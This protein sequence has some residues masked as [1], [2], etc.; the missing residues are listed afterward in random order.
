MVTCIVELLRLLL[1]SAAS[2]RAASTGE[3]ALALQA[4]AD[5]N[6]ESGESRV[7]EE[8]SNLYASIDKESAEDPDLAE[9]RAQNEMNHRRIK[10]HRDRGRGPTRSQQSGEDGW[11]HDFSKGPSPLDAPPERRSRASTQS[12]PQDGYT[13]FSF[14]NGVPPRGGSRRRTTANDVGGASG[15]LY[16]CKPDVTCKV[17]DG[18]RGK[19]DRLLQTLGKGEKLRLSPPGTESPA[20]KKTQTLAGY[21]DGRWVYAR[22][23]KQVLGNSRAREE[24]TRQAAARRGDL[25]QACLEGDRPGEWAVYESTDASLLGQLCDMQA[26]CTVGREQLQETLAEFVGMFALKEKVADFA[27]Q[28]CVMLERK[29]TGLEVGSLTYHL[30]LTGNPGTG[31][32]EVARAVARLLF[33]IGATTEDKFLEVQRSDLVAAATGGTERQTTEKLDE[34]SGGVLFVDEAYQLV[35]KNSRNDYGPQAVNVMMKRMLTNVPVI[36]VAGYRDKMEPFLASN[37]GLERRLKYR[38]HFDDYTTTELAEIFRNKLLKPG[39]QIRELRYD[40]DPPRAR[41]AGWTPWEPNAEVATW[42]TGG[43]MK[44]CVGAGPRMEPNAMM[45]CLLG[46]AVQEACNTQPKGSCDLGSKGDGRDPEAEPNPGDP[47]EPGELIP[48]VENLI[49]QYTSKSWRGQRNGQVAGNLLKAA[50][51]CMAERADGTDDDISVMYASDLVCGAFSDLGEPWELKERPKLRARRKSGAERSALIRNHQQT[52]LSIERTFLQKFGDYRNEVVGMGDI[53]EQVKTFADV[54]MLQQRRKAQL[55]A[56]TPLSLYH[57]I[58]AGPPGTGKT[59]VARTIAQLLKDLGAISACPQCSQCGDL[60]S[61]L[62][63]EVQRDNLVGDVVGATAI[64]TRQVIYFA[65]GGLLFIDEAYT[66]AEGSDSFGQ[67]AINEVM[68]HMNDPS[69]APIVIAA[70][71]PDKM[72]QFLQLNEGLQRRFV[73]RFEFR[74]YDAAELAKIAATMAYTS[75]DEERQQRTAV[76][77]VPASGKKAFFPAGIKEWAGAHDGLYRLR[78]PDWLEPRQCAAG[79]GGICTIEEVEALVQCMIE[80][81]SPLAVRTDRNAALAVELI[82]QTAYSTQQTGTEGSHPKDMALLSELLMVAMQ[83]LGAGL[84]PKATVLKQLRDPTLMAERL[85]AVSADNDAYLLRQAAFAGDLG[86]VAESTAT[87]ETL[88]APDKQGSTALMLAAHNGHSDVVAQLVKMGAI[89]DAVDDSGQ[90]ALMRAAHGGHKEAVETLLRLGADVEARSNQGKTASDFAQEGGDDDVEQVLLQAMRGAGRT[91]PG[92]RAV[93]ELRDRA[94]AGVDPGRGTRMLL[95]GIQ[96][97]LGVLEA[98]VED[99]CGSTLAK[100]AVAELIDSKTHEL[101]TEL[102]SSLTKLKLRYGSLSKRLKRLAAH[103]EDLPDRPTADAQQEHVRFEAEAQPRREEEEA[104]RVLTEQKRREAEVEEE[105]RPGSVPS[106][107]R[108]TTLEFFTGGSKQGTRKKPPGPEGEPEGHRTSGA[109][110][111]RRLPQKPEGEPAVAARVTALRPMRGIRPLEDHSGADNPM[112]SP[113]RIAWR[114]S[115]ARR[116]PIPPMPLL[117]PTRKSSN[118]ELV[119]D[120]S[121]DEEDDDLER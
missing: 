47:G 2:A 41:T 103:S 35:R 50:V 77:Q 3:A 120:S 91:G 93:D 46:S 20:I 79:A 114:A 21:T 61:G 25:T 72:D 116:A 9:L 89:I 82:K 48:L 38:F 101:G 56:E 90:T 8:V 83:I 96:Q 1:L 85:R 57:M 60:S 49:T 5:L 24:S 29:L 98:K 40:L 59:E 67:E 121:S 62:T 64:K 53:L 102:R 106:Q 34:A 84:V 17:Y 14:R 99:C 6:L 32:T 69:P 70:G 88:G 7:G 75:W 92:Q 107:R 22:N 36:I 42:V 94:D 37:A 19:K 31:K 11:N 112:L 86:T 58:F 15:D 33:D 95:D 55:G 4:S 76:G 45:S 52:L 66:L 18:P 74:A 104:R 27:S 44:A 39:Y 105:A 23:F 71:Y 108:P 113:A 117:H 68:R 109:M 100:E 43:H 111:S 28:T 110:D 73:F 80:R 12:R 54:I 51:R 16:E 78:R 63:C 30:V 10:S 119:L 65:R 81:L 87:Q 118:V 13:G 26:R 97:R 115:R